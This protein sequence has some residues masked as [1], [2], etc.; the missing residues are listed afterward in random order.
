MSE[1]LVQK[2]LAKARQHEAAA[3]EIDNGGD[4]ERALHLAVAEAVR[5]CARDLAVG[6][7]WESHVPPRWEVG[8]NGWD[9]SD[10][11]TREDI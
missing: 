1:T 10:E 9:T 3:N 7:R 11:A 5:Q 4:E 2:W 8:K 6:P